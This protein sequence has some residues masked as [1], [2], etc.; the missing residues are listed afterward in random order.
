MTVLTTAMKL[1]MM[2]DTQGRAP[3]AGGRP[4]SPH[5]MKITIDQFK[6]FAQRCV[7]EDVSRPALMQPVR[8]NER[9][10]VSD[11][12][13]ALICETGD[14]TSIKSHEEVAG[15]FGMTVGLDDYISHFNA[16]LEHGNCE[17]FSVAHL[18]AAVRATFD[19]LAPSLDYLRT[20]EPDPDDLDDEVSVESVR[21]V[22]ER[23]SCVILPNRRRSVIAGYYADIIADILAVTGTSCAYVR[24]KIKNSP[25]Y[26]KGENWHLILM[27]LRATHEYGDVRWMS[28]S[29]IADAATGEL[30]HG[31]NKEEPDRVDIDALRFPAKGEVVR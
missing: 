22:Y 18:H 27:P 8:K 31:Y 11:G 16:A 30:L 2:N 19:N 29:A 1:V 3:F 17:A 20:Y 13:I 4:E 25:I 7:S 14:N 9:V 15:S 28:A 10:Y 6:M 24:L 12:R 23:Y 26:A 21:F 5:K